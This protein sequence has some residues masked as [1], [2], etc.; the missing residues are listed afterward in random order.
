LN[1]FFYNY[2]N[3]PY[4]AGIG[5]IIRSNSVK[6]SENIQT[7][8]SIAKISSFFFSFVISTVVSK[9]AIH[10]QLLLLGGI[11]SLWVRIVL[12]YNV[13]NFIK[14]IAEFGL[15]KRI[16]FILIF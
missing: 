8:F 14:R 4:A 15:M 7:D 11:A 10:S 16:V 2:E 3:T 6:K 12:T 13:H 5:S 9:E 1:E